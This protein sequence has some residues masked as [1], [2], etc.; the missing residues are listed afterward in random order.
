MKDEFSMDGAERGDGFG[1]I[2][3]HDMH[4]ALYF[5]YGH[6]NVTSIIRPE[7]PEAAD[8]CCTLKKLESSPQAS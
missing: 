2:Q 3:A 8:H 6:V 7:I 4:C 5:C 1:M